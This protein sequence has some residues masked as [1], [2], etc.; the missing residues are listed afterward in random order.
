MALHEFQPS[1]YA[2]ATKA[3]Q[4]MYL[5]PIDVA[6]NEI[7]TV[8]ETDPDWPGWQWCTDARRKSGWVPIAYLEKLDDGTARMICDYIAR[9]LSVKT[10]EKVLLLRFESGWYWAR[11]PNGNEGWVPRSHLEIEP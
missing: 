3:Y 6:A 7:V 5:D 8:G 4:K 10:G 2:R 9:E 1:K 11:N